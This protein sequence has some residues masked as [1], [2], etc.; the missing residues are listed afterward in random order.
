MASLSLNE[1]VGCPNCGVL[2][3]E[4]ERSDSD[5]EDKQL[6]K[7]VKREASIEMILHRLRTWR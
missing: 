5:H 6:F 3:I 4:D 7:N 1:P 2:E